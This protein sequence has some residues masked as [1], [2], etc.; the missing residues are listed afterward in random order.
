ML[1]LARFAASITPH[2]QPLDRR[3]QRE[4]FGEENGLFLPG[5]RRIVMTMREQPV[6]REYP[7][8]SRS[9]ASKSRIMRACI[10][11]SIASPDP[12]PTLEPP[13]P[14]EASAAAAPCAGGV[15]PPFR[16]PAFSRASWL[17]KFAVARWA[18]LSSPCLR[19]RAFRVNGATGNR[20]RIDAED[21]YITRGPLVSPRGSSARPGP[22]AGAPPG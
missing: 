4:T 7:A 1:T 2:E 15:L 3:R 17:L 13:A 9:N 11:A 16:A 5:R 10:C 12:V 20:P 22:R 18:I 8:S 6:R 19:T 21:P 14:A